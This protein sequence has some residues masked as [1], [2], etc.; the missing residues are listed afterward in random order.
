[1]DKEFLYALGYTQEDRD[2][3]ILHQYPDAQTFWRDEANVFVQMRFA[4]LIARAINNNADGAAFQ[5]VHLPLIKTAIEC[6]RLMAPEIKGHPALKKVRAQIELSCDLVDEWIK[7]DCPM[8]EDSLA[9][10]RRHK[11][12][13]WKGAIGEVCYDIATELRIAY[14]LPLTT[15]Y[16]VSRLSD[17]VS[18]HRDTDAMR[19]ILHEHLPDLQPAITTARLMG[20]V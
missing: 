1:M 17:V 13:Q 6:A 20:V 15:Y 3:L 12:G 2:T 4:A 14:S 16:T 11:V 8:D 5:S 19:G 7:K 18:P 10:M 9:R